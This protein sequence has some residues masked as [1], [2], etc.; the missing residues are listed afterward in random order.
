MATRDM[1]TAEYGYRTEGEGWKAGLH[2]AGT[3]LHR[4][5]QVAGTRGHLAEMDARMLADVG[6]SRSDAFMEMN[7]APWDIMEARRG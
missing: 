5:V 6:L 1:F 2:R 3:W 7:R 4:M